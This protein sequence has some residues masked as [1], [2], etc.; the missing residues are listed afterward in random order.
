MEQSV[1]EGF[2]FWTSFVVRIGDINYGGHMGNDRY[3]LLFQDA[4]IRYLQSQG[5]TEASI[6]EGT[7]VIL[8]EARVVYEGEAFLGDE[9]KVGV[10]I[11]N[12]RRTSFNVEFSAIRESDGMSI[13]SGSTLMMAFDYVNRRVTRIP[14][15]FKTR[16]SK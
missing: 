1:E 8:R 2:D 5:F 15:D 7:G 12:L 13:A 11:V 10:R 14:Q 4:R 3:L 9:I 6:G 16:F